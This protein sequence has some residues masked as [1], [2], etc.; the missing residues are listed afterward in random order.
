MSRSLQIVAMESSKVFHVG[1]E[2]H[3]APRKRIEKD[4]SDSVLKIAKGVACVM[5][6]LHLHEKFA[7]MFPKSMQMH[8]FQHVSARFPTDF[9]KLKDSSIISHSKSRAIRWN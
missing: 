9:P 8:R 4:M 1:K 5:R 7:Y 3:V 2:N 6:I